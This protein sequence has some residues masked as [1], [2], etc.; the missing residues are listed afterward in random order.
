MVEIRLYTT[1]GAFPN[2]RGTNVYKSNP[3][4]SK[5]VHSL[6]GKIQN[7]D[8]PHTDVLES[9]LSCN[10]ATWQSYWVLT[11]MLVVCGMLVV[12]IPTIL[13]RL[14]GDKPWVRHAEQSMFETYDDNF[15]ATDFPYRYV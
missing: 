1:S 10:Y 3:P 13:G 6:E 8:Y 15:F 9:Q 4:C 5:F 7:G 11:F 12:M 14:I 2:F